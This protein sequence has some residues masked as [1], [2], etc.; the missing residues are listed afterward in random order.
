MGQPYEPRSFQPQRFSGALRQAEP[1]AWQAYPACVMARP[2]AASAICS[3]SRRA[4]AGCSAAVVMMRH[5]AGKATPELE[6]LREGK[7]LYGP[8]VSRK[9][10]AIC[11]SDVDT[12]SYVAWV[13]L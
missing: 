10:S 9:Y 3:A 7:A 13:V 11:R 8:S 1:F 2:R 5:L 4:S 12:A 6:H